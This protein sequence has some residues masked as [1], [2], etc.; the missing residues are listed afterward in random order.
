MNGVE[1]GMKYLAKENYIRKSQLASN[2]NSNRF[3]PL[4]YDIEFYRCH[5]FGHIA[6]N[7]RNRFTGSS[8]LFK[9]SKHQSEY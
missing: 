7:C 3:G 6:R 8:N 5:N 9:E 2:R 1:I 4:N